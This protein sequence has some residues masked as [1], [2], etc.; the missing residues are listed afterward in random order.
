MTHSEPNHSARDVAMGTIFILL[1][2]AFL[3]TGGVIIRFVETTD[4]WTVLFYRSVGFVCLLIIVIAFRHRKNTVGAFRAV[5][6]NGLCMA[7]TLGCG[8]TSY[9]FG[10]MLT[11]VANVSF[12]ISAG[13]LFAA[14]FGWIVLRE[15]VSLTTMM[16]IAGAVI[17]MGLMFA[18]GLSTGQMA[19]NLVA[20]GLPLTFGLMVVLIRRA[21]DMDMLPA[22]CMAGMVSGIAGLVFS[23][24]LSVSSS[25]MMIMLA[26]GVVQLGMGFMLIT[27]GTRYIAAAEAALLSLSESVLAPVLAWLIIMEIPTTLALIGGMIV[28]ACVAVQGALGVYRERKSRKLLAAMEH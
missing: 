27:L 18:D 2:G 5:G 22:T 25:D 1:G 28:L 13:P 26:M 10:M 6:V 20:L 7:L 11:T 3:S 12:I 9:V 24:S 17:G 16:V 21:G 8:F 14:V 23:E 19:G 4:S 15:R